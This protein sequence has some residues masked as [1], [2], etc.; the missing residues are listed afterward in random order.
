MEAL[1]HLIKSVST[2]HRPGDKKDILLLA[3][4]R[5]GSTWFM[6]MIWTQPSMRQ[7]SEP[8]N[9]R[10]PRIAKNLGISH[11]SMLYGQDS[12]A[13]VADYLRKLIDNRLKFLNSNPFRRNHHFFTNRTVF[14]CIHYGTHNTRWLEETFDFQVLLILRHPIPV[15]LS[16]KVFPL[17]EEFGNCALREKF[18][19]D[20]LSVLDRARE[21]GSHLEKGIA[22]WCLHNALALR[23][24]RTSWLLATYEQAVIEPE[25]VI[26]AMATHI[27]LH[28]KKR[29]EEQMQKA[30]AVIGKSSAEQQ[31]ILR[32]ADRRQE[33]ISSWRKKVSPQ[34]EADLMGVLEAFHL[35]HYQTGVDLPSSKYLL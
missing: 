13:K 34:Q 35:D 5:G 15:S 23:E 4:P 12:E 8:F 2:V 19:Q 25:K 20:E 24:M 1:A 18:N 6:E 30:S 32:N 10:Q 21:H 29:I 28:E 26:N 16:R 17:L 14:K 27:G 3:T 22:A 31:A 9:I 33:L 11:F 7:C